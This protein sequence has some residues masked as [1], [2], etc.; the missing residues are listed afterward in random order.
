MTED[1]QEKGFLQ[2]VSAGIWGF[3]L[4]RGLALVVLGVFLL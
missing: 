4:L 2:K 1:V 3:I